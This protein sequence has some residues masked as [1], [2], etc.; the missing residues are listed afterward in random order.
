[1]KELFEGYN[2]F[3]EKKN[4][5]KSQRLPFRERVVAPALLGYLVRQVLERCISGELGGASGVSAEPIF[6]VPSAAATLKI[7]ISISD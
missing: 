1:M 7:L 4:I 3:G 5:T 6:S 2:R